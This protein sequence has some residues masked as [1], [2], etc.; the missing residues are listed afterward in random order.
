MAEGYELGWDDLIGKENPD[1]SC[2]NELK[3]LVRNK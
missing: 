1:Y 2:N 3:A